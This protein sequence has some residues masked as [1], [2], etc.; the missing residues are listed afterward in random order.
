MLFIFIGDSIVTSFKEFQKFKPVR[1]IVIVWMVLAPITDLFIASLLVH[2]LV[3]VC[4]QCRSRPKF[5]AACFTDGIYSFV[6]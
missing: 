4:E 5:M 6:R 2:F 1:I 3:R